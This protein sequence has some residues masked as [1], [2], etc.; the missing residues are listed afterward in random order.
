MHTAV[1]VTIVAYDICM[2]NR[3]DKFFVIRYPFDGEEH[4]LK[5]F[6]PLRYVDDTVTKSV[7]VF[8]LVRQLAGHGV[9]PRSS[10]ES[11]STE[12]AYL[13]DV[14]E[15]GAL[16]LLLAVRDDELEVKTEQRFNLDSRELTDERVNSTLNVQE[17]R[18]QQGV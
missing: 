3:Q 15:G 4:L 8:F 6:L 17:V 16:L 12:E 10:S 11:C 18:V 13:A 5:T 9:V 14:E 2:K 7:L 1:G